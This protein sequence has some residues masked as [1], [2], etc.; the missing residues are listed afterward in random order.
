M[1]M[2]DLY[3][4][5]REKSHHLSAMSKL[6]RDLGMPIHEIGAL[7]ESVLEEMKKTARVRDYLSI[8]ASRKVKEFLH[9]KKV[10]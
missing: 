7:Y 10:A 6:A 1:V 3:G 5:E 4:D 8:L 9:G 2:V